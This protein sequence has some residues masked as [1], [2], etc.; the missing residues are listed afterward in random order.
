ME[1]SVL[2]IFL[3]IALAAG[4][5]VVLL[6]MGNLFNPR[7]SNPVKEMPYESGMDPFHDTRRRFDVRYHLVAIA[8]LVF[9]V[10]L[11]FLYPWAV[12]LHADRPPAGVSAVAGSSLGGE[13][14]L[15]VGRDDGPASPGPRPTWFFA[16]GMVFLALLAAGF[17]YDWKKGIFHWR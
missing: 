13:G 8:F 11:L 2:P 9:D 7:R 17:V 12:A 10:E 4:L 16:G 3:F 5:A 14:R 6:V 1:I 15:A